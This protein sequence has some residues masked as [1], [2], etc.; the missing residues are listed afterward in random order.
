[1]STP[2]TAPPNSAPRPGHRIGPYDIAASIGAGGM[3]EVFRARDTRLNRD[4]AVKLLPR[5]FASDGDRLRR[6]EQEARILAALNH[7]CIL[8]IHDA[9]VH[10]GV[11]YLV[12]ELLEGRTLRE[13]L[14]NAGRPSLLARKATELALQIAQGLAAAHGKGVVHRD[15]K[16]ENVFVTKDG[17]VK[18]LDFGLAKLRQEGQSVARAPQG[19]ADA[20]APTQIQTAAVNESTEPGKVMGTPNYMAPE[21]VRGD[22]VDHRADIFSLGCVV[23]EMVSGQRPFKRDTAIATMAAITTDE[24]P[25][26]QSAIP[27]LAPELV[28]VIS[29]CLVK[30]PDARWQTA[31]DLADELKWI[32]QSGSQTS[33]CRPV[34]PPRGRRHW[35]PWAACAGLA[36]ALAVAVSIALRSPSSEPTGRAGICRFE[37]PVNVPEHSYLAS[38]AISPDGRHIAYTTHDSVANKQQ[39]WL[40]SIDALTPVELQK[41]GEKP[42]WSPDSRFVAFFADGKLKKVNVAGGPAQ[43]VCNAADG[44]GGTWNRTG[45]IV[46]APTETSELFQ[47]SSGGG[48]PAPVT[49]LRTNGVDQAHWEIGHRF[50]QFLPDGR[51]FLYFS[52]T[53]SLTHAGTY[54]ASLD[55]GEPRLVLRNSLRGA[56]ASPGYLLFVLEGALV[57]QPLNARSMRLTG[58]AAAI[59]PEVAFF[60]PS[61]E[62]NASASE[63]GALAFFSGWG[64][65]EGRQLVWRDRAGADLERLPVKSSDG[66]GNAS[67]SPDGSHLALQRTVKDSSEVWLL[68]IKSGTPSR[69]TFGEGRDWAPLWSPHGH[70]VIYSSVRQGQTQLYQKPASGVGEEEVLF[71]D[72]VP[73]LRFKIPCDISPDGKYLLYLQVREGFLRVL[74]LDGKSQPVVFRGSTQGEGGG[75]FS[76]DGR[77]VAY[78]SSESGSSQVYVRGFPTAD[79]QWRISDTVGFHPRWNPNG[80]ELF[81][82]RVDAKGKKLMAVEVETGVN[83]AHGAPKPLFDVDVEHDQMRA[84]FMVSTNGQRFL[85]F[86]TVATTN[87][88]PSHPLKLVLNWTQAWSDEQ[89]SRR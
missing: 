17:R 35:L 84:Q 34:P 18:I 51:R 89:R 64:D 12:S 21:Q 14:S 29:K 62:V 73:G 56:Y 86:Q 2:S 71:Q 87:T 80:R 50:P 28:R 88:A 45:L 20:D 74:P 47:V 23:Y 38:L 3:G 59:A 11:P 57:A 72:D 54:A 46:F 1:M 24:P 33:L 58:E 42:F 85:V 61:G 43:I 79:R 63:T 70:R 37:I 60:G 83:F 41:E 31:V 81:Y 65:S 52:R 32:S 67:L 82:V 7:P 40:R 55:G 44:G 8:T 26:L 19:A 76:P 77:W 78:T 4:V 48:A 39:L 69:F 75:V 15:L 68:D 30:D 13:T 53:Q 16:P 5:E 27:E 6:F 36:G 66:F 49:R 25:D 22:V 9:G 10:E